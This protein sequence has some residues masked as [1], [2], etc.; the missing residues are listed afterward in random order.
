M[1]SKICELNQDVSS[2]SA[3]LDE[4][5]NFTSV[6]SIEKKEALRIRLLAEELKR[7]VTRTCW[8]LWWIIL[9]REK[10]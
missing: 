5:E 9:D 1:K 7:N 2:L 6:E 10:W 8:K 3:I 4:V